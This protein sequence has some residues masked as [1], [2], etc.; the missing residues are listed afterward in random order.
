MILACPVTRLQIKQI[1]ALN[2][3]RIMPNSGISGHNV[4]PAVEM[5]VNIL[6]DGNQNSS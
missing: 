2:G 6:T 1:F 5:L 3:M 4:A